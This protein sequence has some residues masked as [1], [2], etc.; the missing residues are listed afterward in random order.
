MAS[1]VADRRDGPADVQRRPEHERDDEPRERRV[2]DGVADEGEALEDDERAHHR[3][4]DADQHRRDE[5]PLHEAIRQRIGHER[6]GVHQR[7]SSW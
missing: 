5:A 6:D 1:A 7:R 2:A 4:D 3:A